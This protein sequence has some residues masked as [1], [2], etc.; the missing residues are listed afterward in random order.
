[1]MITAKRELGHRVSPLSHNKI[2]FYAHYFRD[3]LREMLQ[4]T[5]KPYLKLEV[6]LEALMQSEIINLEIVED[7]NLPGR[8]AVTYPD[9]NKIVL[10]QS[11]YDALCD[12]DKHA[13][14]TVAHELGHLIMHRNQIAY[15][16]DK[17]PGGHKIYEDSEW[18]ADVFASHFLIDARLVTP[19]MSED[20]ISTIFGVSKQAAI[21]W[22]QKNANTRYS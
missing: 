2:K 11:I 15:A 9:K 21:T 10:Q 17:V 8:Y 5:N 13:R 18:Q 22:K 12:G 20:D 3:S 19:S 14:F 1:M 4:I 7:H 16:R 6:I